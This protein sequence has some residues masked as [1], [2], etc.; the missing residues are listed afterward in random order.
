MPLRLSQLVLGATALVAAACAGQPAPDD[1]SLAAETTAV[2]LPTDSA[3]PTPPLPS[4]LPNDVN[5]T[6]RGR[7]VTPPVPPP[8]TARGLIAVVGSQPMTRVT[9]R[10]SDGRTITVSGAHAGALSR[11]A[12]IDV[13][14]GGRRSGTELVATDFV[15]RAVEEIP[16]IDGRLAERRGA[17][18]LIRRDGGSIALR[19]APAA[20]RAHLGRRV[21]VTRSAA[22]EVLSFGLID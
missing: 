20:L 16:A 3:A 17:L 5:S 12:G 21:W 19:S 9:L 6:G 7:G 11:L 4:P 2:P 10:E 15:V 1:D 18:V 8:D 14:V 22:G 13:W